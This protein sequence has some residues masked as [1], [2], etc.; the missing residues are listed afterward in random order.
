[1][2][3]VSGTNIFYL[4]NENVSVCV[5]L[6]LSVCET[7]LCLFSLCVFVYVWVGVWRSL[8]KA[9]WC[10]YFNGLRNL[11]M[12]S[13][14]VVQ[15]ALLQPSTITLILMINERFAFK[16]SLLNIATEPMLLCRLW[17]WN[18]GYWRLD[19]FQL[20][21]KTSCTRGLFSFPYSHWLYD[22]L[23]TKAMPSL[24]VSIWF[25]WSISSTCS[26]LDLSGETKACS[27]SADSC[28]HIY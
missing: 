23:T 3:S 1:M 16:L 22:L 27:T 19:F 20:C 24:A 26:Q 9:L 28:N 2:F 17:C 25:V 21:G 13:L 6:S 11:M 18:F 4:S 7:D 10:T 12:L 5:C 15:F 8:M 14:A